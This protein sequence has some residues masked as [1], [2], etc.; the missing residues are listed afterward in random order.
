MQCPI[1][2][3]AKRANCPSTP[4]Y[5]K[6]RIIK[7]LVSFIEKEKKI[8]STTVPKNLLEFCWRVLSCKHVNIYKKIINRKGNHGDP[9]ISSM[10]RKSKF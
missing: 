9:N 1:Y 7:Q 4:I 8:I 3:G 5:T 2:R 10:K 6:N